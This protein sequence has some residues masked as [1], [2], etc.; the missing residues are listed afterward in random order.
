M[1]VKTTTQ[2][3][4][5]LAEARRPLGSPPTLPGPNRR[6]LHDGEF[7]LYQSRHVRHAGP[8]PRTWSPWVTSFAVHEDDVEGIASIA[9]RANAVLTQMKE[10][11]RAT[12]AR[13]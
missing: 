8:E 2:E 6:M 12:A 10:D 5:V 9:V 13:C 1:I 3:F 4:T 7:M 11:N